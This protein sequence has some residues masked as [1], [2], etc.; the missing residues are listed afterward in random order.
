MRHIDGGCLSDPD[1][2]N[3]FR[4]NPRTGRVYVAW[5]TNTNERDNLD[6]AHRILTATHIGLHCAERLMYCYFEQSNDRKRVRRLGEDDYGTH[7]IESLA[8]INS[9]CKS[10]G[11]LEESPYAK[12]T[13]PTVNERLE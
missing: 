12:I 6:L 1:N 10:L 2:F 4:Y 5:G 7:A 9:C 3:L 13:M 8:F 11:F